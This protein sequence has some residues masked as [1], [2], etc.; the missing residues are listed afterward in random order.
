MWNIQKDIEL[1]KYIYNYSG[2][3]IKYSI[4]KHEPITKMVPY[5]QLN[6]EIEESRKKD[7]W[8][9]TAE[10]TKEIRFLPS[11][12]RN[13]NQLAFIFNMDNEYAQKIIK[14]LYL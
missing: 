3:T 6:Q 14:M 4:P 11:L 2:M 1:E 8:M 5:N 13:D 10:Q 9:W 7:F 12:A